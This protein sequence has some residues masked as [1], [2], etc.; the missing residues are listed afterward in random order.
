MQHKDERAWMLQNFLA[1]AHLPPVSKL[2]H[3]DD[4][5]LYQLIKVT[6]NPEKPTLIGKVQALVLLSCA[7]LPSHLTIEER[8]A[9][10]L[11][12]TTA[13]TNHLIEWEAP[14]VVGSQ[15]MV[16]LENLQEPEHTRKRLVKITLRALVKFQGKP[17]FDNIQVL[18]EEY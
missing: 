6:T 12:V 9:V 4:N 18:V 10:H 1:A 8:N 5:G 2:Y 11:A 14:V 3:R 15:M 13:L 16:T 7:G 17:A